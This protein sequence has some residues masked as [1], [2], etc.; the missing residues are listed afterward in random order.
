[1]FPALRLA[2]SGCNREPLGL[3]G[4]GRGWRGS[5]GRDS[6]NFE[7]AP[8]GEILSGQDDERLKVYKTSGGGFRFLS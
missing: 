1:M 6:E 3:A 2:Q 7:E 4:S 5:N 8:R